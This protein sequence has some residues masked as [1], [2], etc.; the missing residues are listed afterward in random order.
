MPESPKSPQLLIPFWGLG[1]SHKFG[2]GHKLSVYNSCIIHICNAHTRWNYGE[3]HMNNEDQIRKVGPSM[4]GG[5]GL[6][7]LRG[8]PG[9]SEVLFLQSLF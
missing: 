1:F 5:E 7:F 6:G 3:K 8:P 2:G 9:T 4:G